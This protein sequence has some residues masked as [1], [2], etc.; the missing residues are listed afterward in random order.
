MRLRFTLPD[1]QFGGELYPNPVA[2]DLATQLP[3][4]L[5][6]SDYNDVE[7]VASLPRALRV[8]G[9][10]SGADPAPGEI[11]YYAPTKGI[12]LYYGRVG[13]WPGIVRIGRFDLDLDVLRDLP[14]GTVIRI[15]RDD[16][17]A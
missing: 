6:F 7:K 1:A 16:V 13:R 3:L 15:E 10:P 11:S 8:E 2:S 9:V 17:E 4:H 12:V 5:T 14:D